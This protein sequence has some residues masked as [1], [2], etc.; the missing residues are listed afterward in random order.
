MAL[1]ETESGATGRRYA[2]GF[3]R[4]DAESAGLTGEVRCQNRHP[5]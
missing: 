2:E 4:G 1:S 3:A 5:S